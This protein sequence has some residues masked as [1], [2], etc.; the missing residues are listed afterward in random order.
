MAEIDGKRVYTCNTKAKDGMS[1]YTNTPEILKEHNAIMQTYCVNHPLE[2]GV[3][4]KSGERHL[5]NLTLHMK[6]D[7]QNFSIKDSFKKVQDWG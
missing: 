2:C 3:C 1:V 4:D 5:Q 7:S 6:V